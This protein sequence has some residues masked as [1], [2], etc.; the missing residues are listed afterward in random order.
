[1]KDAPLPPRQ[2]FPDSK[3]EDMWILGSKS[4]ESNALKFHFL[5]LFTQHNS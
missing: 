1:M 4:S 5:Q 2:I 3:I